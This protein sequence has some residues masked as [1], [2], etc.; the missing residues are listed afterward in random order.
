M[1]FT[2]KRCWLIHHCIWEKQTVIGYRM[3]FIPSMQPTDIGS[4]PRTFVK[5]NVVFLLACRWHLLT[6]NQTEYLI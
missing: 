5:L 4:I 2:D 6:K 3:D 1:F